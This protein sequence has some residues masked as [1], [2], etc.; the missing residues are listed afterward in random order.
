MERVFAALIYA[1]ASG[2]ITL[3]V[4]IFVRADINLRDNPR[5]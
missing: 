2:Q 1:P 4:A 3:R 5:L